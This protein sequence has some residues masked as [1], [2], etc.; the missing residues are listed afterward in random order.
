MK[1][2]IEVGLDSA[3]W[4]LP[5]FNTADLEWYNIDSKKTEASLTYS[6]KVVLVVWLTAAW[7]WISKYDLLDSGKFKRLVIKITHEF[8]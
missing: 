8:R 7:D 2:P 4:Q 6:T 3:D 1:R 5:V